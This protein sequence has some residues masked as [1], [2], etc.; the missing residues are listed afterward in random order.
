MFYWSNSEFILKV[1]PSGEVS[2]SRLNDFE[3]V[4][5]SVTLFL[6]PFFSPSDFFF[7][8]FGYFINLT[9]FLF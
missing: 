8:V 5:G 2:V 3:V 4:L 7:L 1:V 6:L 9:F